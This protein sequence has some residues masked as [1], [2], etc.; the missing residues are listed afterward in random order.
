MSRLGLLL[1]I[2][3]ACACE[4]PIP[5]PAPPVEPT[6]PP[7]P[8]LLAARPFEVITP[9]DYD[10]GTPLPLLM[11]LHGYGSSGATLDS[12]FD[13][14]RLAQSRGFLLVLPNGSVD[15]LGNRAWRPLA[16]AKTPFDR[17]Y[18]RA[19]LQ[20]VKATYA[21][22]PAR[23]FVF[24]F[25]QGGHMAHRMGC[26]SAD[27]VAAFVSLAGQVP[28][29][30]AFCQPARPISALQVHGTADEAISY[31]GDPT[32]PNIPSAHAII[33]V[34]GRNDGCGALQPTGRTLDLSYEVDGAET[35]VEAFDGCPSGIGV[36]LWT[37]HDV[38]H[39]PAPKPNL[40]TLLYGFLA[41][42]ARN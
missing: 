6:L 26:D 40:R 39:W 34:W 9:L 41:A 29:D 38:H 18:L 12:E 22:D 14:T 27:L 20:S 7:D 4:E 31:D 10:G 21:V 5:V 36:E 24:G 33:G 23:V 15:G 13:L 37:M 11:G 25:S 19:V 3:F 16:V 35:T 32:D 1:L 17:E 8:E 2:C 30:P 28:T 42:H